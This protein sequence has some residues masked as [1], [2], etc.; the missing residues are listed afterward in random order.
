[1]S[2]Y[3]MYGGRKHVT[4]VTGASAQITIRT[5]VERI[6]VKNPFK[7]LS[8]KLYASSK[9]YTTEV[10]DAL[11]KLPELSAKLEY[12]KNNRQYRVDQQKSEFLELLNRV[13]ALAPKQ[14]LEIGGRR[15]GSALLFSIAAGEQASILSIDLDN[16][17]SRIER[18][19]SLCYDKDVVFWQG[20]SHLDET[21]QRLEQYLG[22][23]KIDFLF[24]DGD[25][26]YEGAKEDFFRYSRYVRAGGIIALHDIQQDYKT[27]F[28]VQTNS[29]A[30]GV[31][32]FWQEL[33]V[34]DLNTQDLISDEFQDGYGIGVVNWAG[35]EDAE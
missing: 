15:G 4:L 22:D 17:G 23:S 6:S 27:R 29:W 33:K 34:S 16:S 1:M 3:A 32:Q 7:R 18:L 13:N 8:K 26:S 11:D 21:A 28:D 35:V 2:S 5:K 24:I 14:V 30:G 19:Q 9:A 20:D 10:R 12:M 25:H 31:P